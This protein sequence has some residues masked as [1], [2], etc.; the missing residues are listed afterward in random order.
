MWP[1][2]CESDGTVNWT[3][4]KYKVLKLIWLFFPFIWNF[5]DES[6]KNNQNKWIN[7]TLYSTKRLILTEKLILLKWIVAVWH[8][9]PHSKLYNRIIVWLHFY[10][11]AIITI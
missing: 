4:Y 8:E 5:N 3:F 10:I 11:N 1:K 2:C 6:E 7:L 9:E